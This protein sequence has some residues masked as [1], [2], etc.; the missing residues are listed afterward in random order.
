MPTAANRAKSLRTAVL[1]SD[2]TPGTE[3]ERTF[4]YYYRALAVPQGYPDPDRQYRFNRYVLD[5]AWPSLKVSVELHGGA[6]GGYG[7]P[8]QCHRCGVVV[9]ARKS[10][11]SIGREI[12]LPYPSHS[13]PGSE[14]DAAKG[15]ALQLAGWIALEFTST[16]LKADPNAVILQ[17]TRALDLALTIATRTPGH[18]Q[19]AGPQP[20]Y[21]LSPREIEV[22]AL[23]AK[24]L[25]YPQ[26][27]AVLGIRTATIEKHTIHI[28]Q[29]M[30]ADSMSAAVG[31]AVGEGL[32]VS[33]SMAQFQDSVIDRTG[34][35]ADNTVIPSRP[36][37][38]SSAGA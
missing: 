32:I 20:D 29:K 35:A 10:D 5:R 11:G 37:L 36:T 19:P 4:D 33:D 12:R 15:N 9:K 13:G 3:L 18:G 24:G 25:N 2:Q 14:R 6:G 21:N 7:R 26:T 16:Q 34:Q 38:P 27:A 17:V 28:R 30:G 8:I 22:L 23:L 31:R 1:D